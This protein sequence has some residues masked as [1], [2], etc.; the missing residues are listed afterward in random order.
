MPRPGESLKQP[1]G[2]MVK[3]I[4]GREML[5]GIEEMQRQWGFDT[6]SEALR[7]LVVV[8]LEMWESAEP[9]KGE[10]PTYSWRNT[11]DLSIRVDDDLFR[12]I[13]AQRERS[14]RRGHVMRQLVRYGLWSVGYSP[15]LAA[16]PLDPAANEPL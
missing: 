11:E 13:E 14:E 8:G 4:M 10:P 12:R 1:K 15:G 7:D 3:L 16:S 6:F 9:V 5:E 2:S